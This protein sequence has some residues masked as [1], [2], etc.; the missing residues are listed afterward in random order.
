MPI[1]TKA[2]APTAEVNQPQ[3]STTANATGAF[4]NRR[5]SIT[6]GSDRFV[7]VPYIGLNADQE[8]PEPRPIRTYHIQQRR[9]SGG[10]QHNLTDPSLLTRNP[11]TSLQSN[12][13]IKEM[14][15]MLAK[16]KSTSM[17]DYYIEY[18][19]ESSNISGEQEQLFSTLSK[20]NNVLD[21][22]MVRIADLGDKLNRNKASPKEIHELN[23][24]LRTHKRNLSVVQ[25]HL[26]DLEGKD[27]APE[28]RAIVD[29]FS[30][31]FAERHFDL[32]DLMALFSEILPEQEPLSKGERIGYS[33]LQVKGCLRAI[34]EMPMN[35]RS[36]NK[37]IQTLEAHCQRLEKHA[38]LEKGEY[39]AA[40]SDLSL[41]EILTEDFTLVKDEKKYGSSTLAPL[42]ARWNASHV[43]PA[44]ARKQDLIPLSHPKISQAMLVEL[45]VKNQLKAAGVAES[46]T[47][48]VSFLLRQGIIGEINEQ[49]WPVVKKEFAFR[50]AA[51]KHTATSTIT[52]AGHLAKNFATDYPS[53]GISSMDRMQCK[54]V[55]NMAHSKMTTENN[56]VLFSGIRHGV[57]DPYMINNKNLKNLPPEKLGTLVKELLLETGAVEMP[58]GTDADTYAAT[59]ARQIKEGNTE[60]RDIAAKL[61]AESSK[62]MAKELLTAAVVSDP[63]KMQTALSGETVGVSLN[64]ISLVTPDALRA[65]F[66]AGSG[67]DEKA[68]LVRQTESLKALAASGEPM[69]LTVRDNEGTPR[70]IKVLP[71]VRTLNFG[72]NKGA[73]ATSQGVLGP[74]TP[75]WGKAMG[76]GFA[77]GMNNPE[78]RDML[79]DPENRNLGGA[80][81]EKVAQ[82]AVSNDAPTQRR[83][84]LLKQAATQAK[85]IWRSQSF[86]RGG[87]E[88]YKMVSRLA[89]VS[90]LMGETTLYNCK[91]GKDR[92]GQLDAEA[93]YLAAVGY[94]TGNIPE[95]DAEYTRESRRER[96]NFA[97]NTG[98]HEMQQ[99][100]VG[101]KGY[102]L[103]GVPGLAKGIKADLMDV[104]Q[105]GSKFVKT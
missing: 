33:L 10:T 30:I 52:P 68:M 12:K 1:S 83:A 16:P 87:K 96:T 24:L 37:I 79:G 51:G 13:N 47:P 90:H 100:T 18:N 84:A 105:G 11:N 91:S 94:T 40:T 104:Y 56:E 2:S 25:A 66:K 74:N 58:S 76:W 44:V 88:P 95:P 32:A 5:V 102:K 39:D 4:G 29:A 3:P 26:M 21:K 62:M 57:L 50:M 103:K 63:Q 23:A 14:A 27:L 101:L 54:H 65:R 46:D 67:S 42:I 36:Q 19:C 97:L 70:S 73:V 35:T 22:Q 92:T 9:I 48:P 77:A 85:A 93:K 61:R 69:T 38:K 53:N 71:K 7:D 15:E 78:L 6:R 98:N 45:F 86:K 34:K 31:R 20:Y 28:G 55:P 41:E 75:L 43:D 82:M 64:S 8:M 17:L 59:I 81:A 60:I 80:V 99:M 49:E 89:L 72:V